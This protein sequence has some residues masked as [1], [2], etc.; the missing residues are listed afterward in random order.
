MA[1]E[2]T[3]DRGGSVDDVRDVALSE[4]F[5]IACRADGADIEPGRDGAR[6]PVFVLRLEGPR[7]RGEQRQ[8]VGFCEGKRA[9]LALILMFL[10]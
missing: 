7:G 4:G 10:R 5:E 9:F 6:G 8:F 3:R 2:E 1:L